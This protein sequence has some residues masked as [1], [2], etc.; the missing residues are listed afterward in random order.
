MDELK[1]WI[2]VRNDLKMPTGKLLAQAGHAVASAMVAA[3]PER[4]TEYMSHNQ[5]KIAVK[6][7]NLLA[8]ERAYKESQDAGLP[9]AFIVDEGRTVF[10]EPTP[11]VVGI[12]PCYYVDLPK[13]VQRLQLL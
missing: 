12:G 4:V 8:L 7:K 6:V 5:P 3:G 10:G 1:I 2:V 13:F 11:T 9:C